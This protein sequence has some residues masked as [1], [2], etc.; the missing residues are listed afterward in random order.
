[1]L[2]VYERGRERE[3]KPIL[4]AIQSIDGIV[5]QEDQP[6]RHRPRIRN[7]TVQNATSSRANKTREQRPIIFAYKLRFCLSIVWIMGGMICRRSIPSRYVAYGY[8]EILLVSPCCLIFAQIKLWDPFLKGQRQRFQAARA[9][10]LEIG[11]FAWYLSSPCEE[12]TRVLKEFI[13]YANSYIFWR[14]Q[15]WGVKGEA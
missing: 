13:G 8:V 11:P 15:R 6:S 12:G 2:W 14:L 10:D 9:V 5:I 3:N 7:Y 1:M 4:P